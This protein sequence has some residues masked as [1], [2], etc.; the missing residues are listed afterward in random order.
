M[1]AK[2]A[3]AAE[4][5]AAAAAEEEKEEQEEGA[6]KITT[7]LKEAG[8]NVLPGE[9]YDVIFKSESLGLK[10]APHGHHGLPT[11]QQTKSLQIDHSS[12]TLSL[13]SMAKSLIL[14]KTRTWNSFTRSPTTSRPMALTF[15]QDHQ[16]RDAKNRFSSTTSSPHHRLCRLHIAIHS[17][18]T[19]ADA[20]TANRDDPHH[21]SEIALVTSRA[22]S[23]GHRC[24]ASGGESKLLRTKICFIPVFP[25]L[26]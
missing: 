23:N 9:C 22:W 18:D 7:R 1:K 8:N 19:V 5:E 26:R 12:A 14:V 2:K 16:F 21:A 25:K 17:T 10:F 11:V 24:R 13:P 3:A 6:T 4:A 20:V 15:Q